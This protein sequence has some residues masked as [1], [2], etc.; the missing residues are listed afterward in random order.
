M[1]SPAAVK[2]YVAR[3]M[4]LGKRLHVG[5]SPPL[6]LRRGIAGE[7]Y[8]VA[9]EH[10]WERVL[11]APAHAYLEGEEATIGDMLGADWETVACARCGL[12]HPCPALGP[13]PA[14][15]CPCNDL[16]DWPNLDTVAPHPPV[17]TF[18]QLTAI[19]ARLVAREAEAEIEAARGKLATL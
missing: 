1:A 16:A 4:E 11:A 19:Q 13:R 6:S 3:W 5:A 14:L 18:E 15:A 12:P 10:L 7:T 2:D 17:R 8:S 9:F